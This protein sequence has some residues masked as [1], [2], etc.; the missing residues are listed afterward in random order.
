M[1]AMSFGTH[2][3]LINGEYISTESTFGKLEKPRDPSSPE[4]PDSS[5]FLKSASVSREVLRVGAL[6]LFFD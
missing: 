4:K 5:C 2:V 6:G 1:W 3:P